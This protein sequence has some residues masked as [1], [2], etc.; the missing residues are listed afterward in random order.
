MKGQAPKDLV[1]G[2]AF[3]DLGL[4][5]FRLPSFCPS[6][7]KAPPSPK[8]TN[9]QADRQTNKQT[10][11]QVH[12]QACGDLRSEE[13]KPAAGDLPLSMD[14]QRLDD[15]GPLGHASARPA[16][17]FGYNLEAPSTSFA[18]KHCVGSATRHL[19][20]NRRIFVNPIS[21]RPAREYRNMSGEWRVPNLSPLPCVR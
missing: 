15:D 13:S 21:I 1:K 19:V 5:S 12:S 9:K 6:A 17:A 3:Q 14:P 18:R 11:K 20:R 8:Q 7:Q 10:D 16:L 2:H 4:V